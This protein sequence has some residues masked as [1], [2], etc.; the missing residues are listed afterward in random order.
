[1]LLTLTPHIIRTPNISEDDLLPVWVGTEQNITFR[2]GS[3]RIESEVE[4]GPFEEE[5]GATPEEIQE[6]IRERLQRLPRGLQQGETP[7]QP[8]TPPGGLEL[9]PGAAPSDAF[10]PAAKPTPPPPQDTPQPGVGV[11]S[12]EEPPG[13]AAL[14][15]PAPAVVAA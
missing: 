7:A 6:K 3:P 14:A 10:R 5:S 1:M 9:A 12:V 11:P 4:S 8:Q 15:P 2:G 13:M